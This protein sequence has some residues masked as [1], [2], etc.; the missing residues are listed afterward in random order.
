MVS[1]LPLGTILQ[2]QYRIVR[3]LGIGGMGAVYLAEDEQL[4]GKQWAIKELIDA[5]TN[6]QDRTA[7]W[8]QFQQEARI[9]V[10]L[11]HP[12]LP[13]I[14]RHFAEGG[15]L[16]LVMEY[17]DGQTLEEIL[18]KTSGPLPE[19]QVVD[20]MK[21]ICGVLGYLHGCTPP[22]IFRDLKPDNIMLGRDN[23]IRLIDFGIA[24]LFDPHKQ[25]DTLKMGTHGYAPPE[26]YA[27]MGRTDARSDI[28]GLGATMYHLLT[29][30]VPVEAIARV[31]PQ[32]VL[33]VSPRK[34]N[35]FLSPASE[36]IILTAMAEHPDR[37]YQTAAQM[38]AALTGRAAPVATP[39]TA[40]CPRCGTVNRATARFCTGCGQTMALVPPQAVAPVPRQAPAPLAAQPLPPAARQAPAPVAG[41][42]LPAARQA[43]ARVPSQLP[44]AA[45]P[46]P[47]AQKPAQKKRGRRLLPVLGVGLLA[48]LLAVAAVWFVLP[49]LRSG[50]T[51]APIAPT[52][53]AGATAT[54]SGPSS[55]AAPGPSATLLPGVPTVAPVLPVATAVPLVTLP[56]PTSLPIPAPGAV[57]PVGQPWEQEG[58]SLV[59]SAVAIRSESDWQD[60]AVQVW[61]RFFNKTG[62]RLLVDIDW[63]TIHL[64]DSLG[65]RYLDWEAGETTSTWVEPGDSLNFDRSYTRQPQERSRVPS[66]AAFVQVVVDRFGRVANAR[67]EVRINPALAPIAAPDPGSVRGVGETWEQGGLALT[68][69][70]IQVRAEG[71]WQEAAAQAWF[72]LTNRG[73]DRLLVE[74]DFG[75]IYLVDGFGRRFSD[76]EGGGRWVTWLEPGESREFDRSYSE[77]AGWK[78]RVTRGSEFVL[79]QVEKLGPIERAQWRFDIVR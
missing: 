20:W 70:E 35:P 73:S 54:L 53:V 71:D 40:R 11:D 7:A 74:V 1:T 5:F 36:Q 68:L 44:A 56:R 21:Q 28:Y 61:F 32:P 63:S 46:Q 14:V 72:V 29:N 38:E 39:A 52:V 45:L 50:V 79:L 15:R 49:R 59:V 47:Q 12:N 60:A 2:G 17:V 9:L 22:V 76:W 30:Q 23:R 13:K 55:T 10:A 31:L 26:Q 37:R 25:T 24:R 65:N 27:G 18:S 67:W 58:V 4:F 41:Q 69:K 34:L 66:G 48:V 75:H 3:V 62:D 77:M 8:Q 16:Y 57:Y 78:S 19:A 64:E 42:P 43:P 6:P 51:P 33:L